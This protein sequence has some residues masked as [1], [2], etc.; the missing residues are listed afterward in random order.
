[1]KFLNIENMTF[2]KT[3]LALGVMFALGSGTAFA[4]T[5]SEADTDG[6]GQISKDE[7]YGYVGDLGVY[8]DWDLNDDDL[9]SEDEWTEVD[10]GYEYDFGTWDLNDDGYLDDD[11]LFEGTFDNFDVDND[12]YLDDNEWDDAGDEG[13]MDV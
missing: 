7:Y 8:A 1:M 3:T 12:Y 11:E 2:R 10:Y 13:W 6:N 9:L 5:F 4:A